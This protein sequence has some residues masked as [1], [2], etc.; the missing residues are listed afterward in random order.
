[1]VDIAQCSGMVD[2]QQLGDSSDDTVYENTI[3][4]FLRPAGRPIGMA[5]DTTDAHSDYLRGV[6]VTALT[7]VLGIIAAYGSLVVAGD[8][9]PAEAATS[10]TVVYVLAA[11][12]AVQFPMLKL[13]GL[14]DDFSGKDIFYVAFM[15]FA[16]WFVSLTILL[17]AGVS[18]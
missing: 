15:T 16:F 2:P 11:A 7:A 18:V 4:R 8:V 1:M 9:A 17:T 13:S 10:S 12:I 14:K 5:T 6:T 3:E